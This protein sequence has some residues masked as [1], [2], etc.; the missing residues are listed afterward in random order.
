ML[1]KSKATGDKKLRDEDKFFFEVGVID[2]EV[3]ENENAGE[4]MYMFFSKQTSCGKICGDTMKHLKRSGANTK[5]A[6]VDSDGVLK[7]VG[8]LVYVI[9]LERK[10]VI[11]QFCK[12]F[13]ISSCSDDDGIETLPS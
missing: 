4:C 6:I 11:S 5:L 7:S 12:V 1:I 8:N 10:N 9:D 3:D 2:A 13:V